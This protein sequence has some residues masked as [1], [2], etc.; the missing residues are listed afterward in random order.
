MAS[1]VELSNEDKWDLLDALYKHGADVDT[2][3]ELLPTWTKSEIEQTIKR[4]RNRAKRKLQEEEK[5]TQTAALNQW[6]QVSENLHQLQGSTNTPWWRKGRARLA[7]EP[8]DHAPILSRALMYASLFEDHYEGSSPDDVNYSEIYMYLSHLVSGKEPIQ[9]SPGSAAKILEMLAKMK[10]VLSDKSTLDY[11]KHLLNLN[12][13]YLTSIKKENKKESQNRTGKRSTSEVAAYPETCPLFEEDEG[14]VEAVEETI[15]LEP[16][17]PY[18]EEK[19][20]LLVKKIKTKQLEA[21]PQVSSIPGLNPMEIPSKFL[22]KPC[23][24]VVEAHKF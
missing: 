11:M 5:Q 1:A 7:E 21:I 2:L 8:Q 15:I 6:H 23:S 14:E 17:D 24:S 22:V 3:H 10:N 18:Y 19:R 16:G 13:S 12:V 4:F 9:V 20:E